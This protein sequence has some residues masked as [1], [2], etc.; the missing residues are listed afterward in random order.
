M[1]SNDDGSVTLS[2]EEVR[3][4]VALF[5]SPVFSRH[6]VLCAPSFVPAVGTLFALRDHARKQGLV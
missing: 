5:C 3:A 4:L 1:T 2:G 6:T